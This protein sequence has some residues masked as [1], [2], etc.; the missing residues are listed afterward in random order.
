MCCQQ[1][2]A[3]P[4]LE[5]DFTVHFHYRYIS[6]PTDGD[7]MY[8]GEQNVVEPE[9]NV[10][11]VD[12]KLETVHCNCYIGLQALWAM[13]L[14]YPLVDGP[15]WIV[16]MAH[17][18]WFHKSTFW[19][20]DGCQNIRKCKPQSLSGFDA[21]GETCFNT[22]IHLHTD[23]QMCMLRLRHFQQSRSAPPIRLHTLLRNTWVSTDN[24]NRGCKFLC[25]WF[26][27]KIA[28]FYVVDSDVPCRTTK[29]GQRF[30]KCCWLQMCTAFHA[31]L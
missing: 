10:G 22:R 14:Q 20:F 21:K 29:K 13:H 7:I 9:N 23:T 19:F 4:S 2:V 16:I 1:V 12:L 15:T 5:F 27:R 30:W 26:W 11:W 6:A 3:L 18:C 31:P 24:L 17:M 8:T 25:G 28:R